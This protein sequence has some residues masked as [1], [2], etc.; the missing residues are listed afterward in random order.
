MLTASVG[1]YSWMIGTL[2]SFDVHPGSVPPGVLHTYVSDVPVGSST[3]NAYALI[4]R[5]FA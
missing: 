5:R 4:C 3:S 1:T 2:H